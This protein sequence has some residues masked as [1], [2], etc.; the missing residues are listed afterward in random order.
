MMLTRCMAIHVSP[1]Y[2][3]GM[4]MIPQKEAMAS[5]DFFKIEILGKGGHGSAPHDSIGPNS[6]TN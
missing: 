3:T 6:S 1:L 5:T 4:L 2:K